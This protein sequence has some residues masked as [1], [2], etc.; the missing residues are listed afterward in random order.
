MKR[1]LVLVGLIAAGL[2][3]QG[4][5][6]FGCAPPVSP[7]TAVISRVSGNLYLIEG[8][9]GNTAALV[10]DAGVV[11]VD[12]KLPGWGPAILEQLRTVTSRPVTTII[13]THTHGDHVGGNA[14]FPSV[15]IIAQENTKAHLLRQL[16]AE[17]EDDS[18]IL[19]TR[20]FADRMTLTSGTDQI[21]VYYF[22]AGHTNGD[23][24]VVFPALHTAHVGDLFAA[25]TP[26]V[27]DP[28]HGGSGVAF[29]ETLSKIYSGIEGV[30]TVITG[31]SRPL[32]TWD[33]VRDY[34][35]FNRDFLQF[36]QKELNAGISPEKASGEYQLPPRFAGYSAPRWQVQA[37]LQGIYQELQ[38]PAV[39]PTRWYRGTS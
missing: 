28:G 35:D 18:A 3:S 4:A 26:P 34:G 20:T 23:A 25:K 24:V 17:G 36:A 19:P 30:Q 14:F 10:T 6:W 37:N 13:N 9:G 38:K 32:M 11:L 1:L 7:M 15:E 31:H 5:M 2:L 12:T 39:P 8:G 22:G 33:D 29:P 16:Q 27:I 21:D